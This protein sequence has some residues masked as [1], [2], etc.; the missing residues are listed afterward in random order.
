M[1]IG[2]GRYFRFQAEA[3]RAL[4]VVIYVNELKTITLIV[5]LYIVFC[6]IVQLYC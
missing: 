3:R 1:K 4:F 5:V 2:R 6:L